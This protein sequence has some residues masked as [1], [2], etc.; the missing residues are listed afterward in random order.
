[1]S[2]KLITGV[3]PAGRIERGEMG[4][5]RVFDVNP[6]DVLARRNKL[7]LPQGEFPLMIAASISTLQNWP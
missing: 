2:K 3:K 4:D 1:M 5:S 6:A 7:G